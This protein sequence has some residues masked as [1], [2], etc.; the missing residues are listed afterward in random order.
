LRVLCGLAGF[1]LSVRAQRLGGFLGRGQNLAGL[2]A[3]PLKLLLDRI[4]LTLE[5]RF[6]NPFD[7]PFAGRSSCGPRLSPNTDVPISPPVMDAASMQRFQ[8]ELPAA[9]RP[10][11]L[12][13]FQCVTDLCVG[14]RPPGPDDP[15]RGEEPGD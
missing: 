1:L 15:A 4:R 5:S 6:S 11:V 14:T 2:A 12:V 8:E 13:A 3:D 7:P 10:A 9:E